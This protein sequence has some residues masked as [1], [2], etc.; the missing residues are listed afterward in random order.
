MSS[1]KIVN[2]N[3]L[4]PKK[5]NST[6]TGGSGSTNN[7]NLNLNASKQQQQQNLNLKQNLLLEENDGNIANTGF[8]KLPPLFTLRNSNSNGNG[9][10]YP[11]ILQ[12][13]LSFSSTSSSSSSPSPASA[14]FTEIGQSKPV[15]VTA[16]MG[17]I[18]KRGVQ[19]M[20]K[21]NARE[22]NRVKMVRKYS[23]TSFFLLLLLLP[24]LLLS[25]LKGFS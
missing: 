22:R 19:T 18:T 9:S 13:P 12:F 3:I 7:N 17:N 20:A 10:G 25:L 15:A 2:L 5:L 16:T 6:I 8:V 21:R 1:P 11:N 24:L 14:S 4:Q 23:Y